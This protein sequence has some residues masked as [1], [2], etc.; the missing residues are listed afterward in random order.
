MKQQRNATI[1][2]NVRLNALNHTQNR[3][4]RLATW[5]VL[6]V[7]L[8]LG[9]AQFNRA[10]RPAFA[11]GPDMRSVFEMVNNGQGEAAL[12]LVMEQAAVLGNWGP[13]PGDE[14][15]FDKYM[16]RGV[17]G[18]V[19]DFD[20]L[21]YDCADPKVSM[22]EAVCL[23]NFRL[24]ERQVRFGRSLFTTPAEDGT[25]APRPVFDDLLSTYIE[26]VGHSWQEYLYET[27]G[28]SSPQRTRLT[29]LAEAERWAPGR[30]YQIKR[31]I[32]ALDGD[33]LALSGQQREALMDAIC[34]GYASPI[35]HEVPGYSAPD[36]W[37][38]AAAW[39]VTTPTV[40]ELAA[41]CTG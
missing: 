6:V 41:L 5:L 9:A 1:A 29:S 33:L 11:A 21:P 3:R 8:C 30:E 24:R 22:D 25:I 19:Q 18:A 31:Y 23:E 14:V 2:R 13:A 20:E 36:S 12:Q 34:G 27:D 32:L 15:V 16:A 4:G 35:G 10:A 17:R 26:E 39:P 37:P 28:L 40:D 38:E 7:V